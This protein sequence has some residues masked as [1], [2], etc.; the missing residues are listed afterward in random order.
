MAISTAVDASAVARVVGIKTQ[1]KNLQ[2]GGIVNLPQRVAIF[3][4]AASDVVHPPI[5]QQ[6]TSATDAAARYGF[7]SPIHLSALQ[8][9]P[10]NGDGVGTIPVTVYPLAEGV[11]AVA[12]EIEITVTGVATESAQY[13][14]STNNITAA[15]FVAI[16]GDAVADVA[17][18]IAASINADLNQPVTAAAVAGVVTLTAKWKGISGNDLIAI[19]DGPTDAGVT[20]AITDAAG[21]LIDPDITDAL[22]LMGDV[23]ETMVVNCLGTAEEANLDR[24][25]SFGVGR[26]GAITR[27]PLIVFGGSTLADRSAAT[28]IT[29][30]R[31]DDYVNVQLVEPASNDLPFVVASRELARVVVVANNNPPTDYGSQQ[32]TGLTPGPDGEQ[33]DYTERDVAVKAGTSTITV[34]DGVTTLSDT[35]TMY[36]PSGD[37]VPAYRYVVDIVK[38]QNTL[39]NLDLIFATDSWDGAP[40]IPD[41]QATTNPLAKTPKAARIE[42]FAMLDALALAAIISDPDSAKEATIAEI[43]SQNPKRLNLTTTVKL[44]G[45]ANIISVDLNFGFYFGG[46]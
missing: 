41:G 1:F 38:L 7:G 27:K 8:L 36:H 25:Q 45:N 9:F 32:A 40:L 20:F 39:F 28:A 21:G 24:F 35:V 46:A 4:Q 14:I 15:P 13:S 11:A 31:K 5:K 6:I 43:D 19:I 3:G 34:R 42:V 16:A 17:T 33:W 10:T 2:G 22:A 29:D 37:P 30:T 18:N 12:A 26:W 23:W 44:G